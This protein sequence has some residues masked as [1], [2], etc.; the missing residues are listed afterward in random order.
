[1][2]GPALVL[3]A[4]LLGSISFGLV[5]ARR[6]GIDLRTVGSGNIGAT[7]VGRALGKKTGIV[8]MVLDALKGVLP[9][10]LARLVLT[11]QAPWIAGVAVAAV[12]GHLFPVWHGFRGGKGVATTAGV[13]LA[14]VPIGGAAM[15]VT[16]VALK[17]ATRRSSVGSLIGTLVALGATVAFGGAPWSDP[18]EARRV[19][20]AMAAAIALLVFA[21]HTSNI[22]RL[23]RGEE[24][25]S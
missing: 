15:A 19:W 7:N 2:L 3:A 21:R 10:V 6:A 25:E 9:A 18:P 14:V 1:V 17:K 22:R 11:G 4:Y 12:V 23:F 24:L 13:M 5:A 20:V 16:Y 8:V